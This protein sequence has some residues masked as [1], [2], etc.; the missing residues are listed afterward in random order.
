MPLLRRL[1]LLLALE[2]LLVVLLG[3][4]YGLASLTDDSERAPAELAAAGAVLAGVV[5]LLLARAVDRQRRWARSPAVVLNVLPLPVALGVLQAGVW[6]VGV[7]MLLLAG[8][9]LYLFATPDL[10]DLFR[11]S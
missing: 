10:R 3:V 11:E 6:W 1:A 8:S 7:P 2:G 9:V 4:G 5:L